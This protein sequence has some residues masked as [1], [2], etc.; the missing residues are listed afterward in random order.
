MA[1]QITY[2]KAY[3]TVAPEDFPAML[4]VPRYGRRTSAFDG[5]I[6]APNYVIATLTLTIDDATFDAKVGK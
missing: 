4:K 6:S 3:D 2:D 1:H 5:I